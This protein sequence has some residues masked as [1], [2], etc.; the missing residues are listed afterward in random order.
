MGQPNQPQ[1]DPKE[2]IKEQK[3]ILTRSQRKIERE[4]TKLETQT[5]KTLAEIKKLATKGQHDAAKILAKDVAR[6]R[7]QAKSFMMMSS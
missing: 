4:C 5:K 1:V 3:R 7:N 6:Q 2:L